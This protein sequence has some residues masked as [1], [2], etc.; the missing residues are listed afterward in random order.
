MAAV[1][2]IDNGCS[3]LIVCALCRSKYTLLGKGIK[4]TA[5]DIASIYSEN[6]HVNSQYFHSYNMHEVYC[7]VCENDAD[8]FRNHSSKNGHSLDLIAVFGN[9]RGGSANGRAAIPEGCSSR[10]QRI[11]RSPE[12]RWVCGRKG[13]SSESMKERESECSKH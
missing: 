6:F 2:F 9:A 12:S 8:K 13:G 4:T 3:V 5:T 7:G 10:Q 11:Q 1:E